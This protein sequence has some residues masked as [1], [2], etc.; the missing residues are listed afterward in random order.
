MEGSV[1]G[2]ITEKD[3]GLSVPGKGI[4]VLVQAKPLTHQ[5]KSLAIQAIGTLCMLRVKHFQN[6]LPPQTHFSPLRAMK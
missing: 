5:N 1:H 2:G 6:R 4:A 3:G